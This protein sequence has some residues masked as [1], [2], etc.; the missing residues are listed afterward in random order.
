MIKRILI[1]LL[2]NFFALYLGGVF[3]GS[4]VTSEWYESL[5]KAPWTPPG[6]MFGFAWTLIMICF[7]IYMA[8]LFK[9]ENNRNRLIALFSLQWILNVLWSML[10]FYFESPLLG[11]LDILCL[12]ALIG[13]F[14]YSYRG[15]MYL[16]SLWILPYFVWLL[17]AASLNGYILLYN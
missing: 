1:F 17:L 13:Y 14:L 11:M 12:T 9:V 4:G 7:S 15:N 6:W 16:M 8:W 5:N 10:F 3:T 2:I